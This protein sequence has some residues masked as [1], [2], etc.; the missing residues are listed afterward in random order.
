MRCVSDASKE[1]ESRRERALVGGG[2][3]RIEAQHK[4]V[5]SRFLFY[6]H[7][8]KKRNPLRV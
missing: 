1:L 3:D 7:V 2:K 5:F 8:K 4:K 6:L